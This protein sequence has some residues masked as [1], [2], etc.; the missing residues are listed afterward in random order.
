[1]A[2]GHLASTLLMGA[3]AVAVVTWVVLGRKWYRYARPADLGFG[4]DESDATSSLSW[5]VSQPA[6]W[7]GAFFVLALALVG[8]VVAFV[9]SPTGGLSL[10]PTVIGG[11]AVLVV[12]YLL[13]GTYVSAARRGHPRSLAAAETVSVGGALFLLAVVAQLLAA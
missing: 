13:V 2:T 9:S 12:G 6:V 4:P 5:F 10:G 7:M 8:G 1:M 3:F 11:M